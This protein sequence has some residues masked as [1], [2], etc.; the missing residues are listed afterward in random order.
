MFIRDKG[1]SKQRKRN[2]NRSLF[3]CIG[4]SN[5][6]TTPIHKVI[7]D[8]KK[9]HGLEWIRTSMSYHR[10]TNLREMFMGDL[11]RKLTND[12]ISTEFQNETCNCKP[13]NKKDGQCR[14]DDRCRNKLVIY[15]IKCIN[16]GKEYVGATQRNVKERTYQHFT[17]VMRLLYGKRKSDSY[18]RHFANEFQN[19]AHPSPF[20]LNGDI[21]RNSI[22]ISIIWQG[23]PIST[24]K[25]FGTRHCSLCNRERLEI[26]KRSRESPEKLINSCN[27]IYGACRHKP[28]FHKY[29]NSPSTDDSQGG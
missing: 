12:V 14:F 22:E 3:F 10:F 4:H 25:T 1:M 29:H 27:E 2:R 6:W 8:L 5:A 11:S 19:F 26:L 24:V 9:S 28:R 13:G 20:R 18:A 15:C 21:Q 17:D 16:S 7:N 23:N